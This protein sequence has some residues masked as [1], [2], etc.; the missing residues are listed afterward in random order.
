MC[1]CVCVCVCYVS[2]PLYLFYHHIIYS[3]QFLSC[4][5]I[6]GLV[7]YRTWCSSYGY[8]DQSH[9]Y[10]SRCRVAGE[11]LTHPPHSHTHTHTHTSHPTL[12]QCRISLLP[13]SLL[14][15]MLPQPLYLKLGLS[16]FVIATTLTF[17]LS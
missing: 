16:A 17:A 5:L 6:T 11:Y 10:N 9:V 12:S 2:Q 7:M 15:P 3:R 13:Y 14:F 8:T 4:G 1:V